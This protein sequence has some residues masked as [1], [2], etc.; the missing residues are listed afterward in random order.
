MKRSGNRVPGAEPTTPALIGAALPILLTWG[1]CPGS[2]RTRPRM[3]FRFR[4]KFTQ[5]CRIRSDNTCNP[6]P[7]DIEFS[8]DN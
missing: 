4:E 6:N 1:G 5:P 3:P 2:S 7:F 8:S